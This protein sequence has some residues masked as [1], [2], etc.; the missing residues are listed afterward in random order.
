[1]TLDDKKSAIKTLIEKGKKQG[2]LDS[3]EIM[4]ILEGLDIDVKQI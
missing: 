2:K 3:H 1:M 4:D